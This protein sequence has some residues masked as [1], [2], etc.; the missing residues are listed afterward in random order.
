M[1]EKGL[2]SISVIIHVDNIYE[3]RARS[4][5]VIFG[6]GAGRVTKTDA[7]GDIAIIV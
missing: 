5:S 7:E 6:V 2:I 3:S 4:H 1:E